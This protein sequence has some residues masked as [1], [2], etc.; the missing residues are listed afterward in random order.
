MENTIL[1][2]FSTGQI[3][4]SKAWRQLFE[5]NILKAA[6]NVKTK[7]IT[8]KPVHL[9][10]IEDTNLISFK[11]L[12]TDLSKTNFSPEFKKELLDNYQKSESINLT[13]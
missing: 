3:T 7:E 12:K 5:T 1:K 10:E 6:L 4:I 8:I 9:V 2:I 13:K 11:Q